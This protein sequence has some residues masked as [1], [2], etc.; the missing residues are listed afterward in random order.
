M[1][2]TLTGENSWPYFEEIQLKQN[3]NTNT[4][5]NKNIGVYF[6]FTLIFT[7]HNILILHTCTIF[8]NIN[9]IPKNILNVK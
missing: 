3:K 5:T 9:S 6:I 1:Q 7:S 2:P 4:N 8:L